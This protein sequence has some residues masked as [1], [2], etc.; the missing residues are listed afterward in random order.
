MTYVAGI[1]LILLGVLAVPSLI[2]SRKP[3]AKEMFA[4][5]APF[6]GWI[7]VGSAV[8]G[9]IQLIRVLGH[10][11]V[12]EFS[13]LMGI[14]WLAGAVLQLVL[15]LLL[16]VGVI[17]TFVSSD[18]ANAKMDNLMAKLAPKQGTFGI[19]GIIVGLWTIIYI[20]AFLPSYMRF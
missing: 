13:F 1:W 14:T 20:A 5:I 3:E 18:A 11:Q 15:G 10:L 9:L 16:G 2:I 4:K 7:G 17:K 12:F 6:Q 8:W 19:A